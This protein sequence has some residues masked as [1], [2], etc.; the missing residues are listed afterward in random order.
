MTYLTGCVLAVCIV[1]WCLGKTVGSSFRWQPFL[2]MPLV[3]SVIV[4]MSGRGHF[5][6]LHKP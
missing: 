5:V 4:E 6:F 1:Y 3:S 2:P